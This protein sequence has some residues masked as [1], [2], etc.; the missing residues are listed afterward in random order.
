MN[1]AVSNTEAPEEAPAQMRI[2]A[3]APGENPALT[4]APKFA[5]SRQAARATERLPDLS[6]DS[7]VAADNRILLPTSTHTRLTLDLASSVQASAEERN[8]ADPAFR[9]KVIKAHQL[10]NYR[11]DAHNHVVSKTAVSLPDVSAK[12]HFVV[13]PNGTGQHAIV[14][15]CQR[16]FNYGHGIYE[17]PLPG[18]AQGIRFARMDTIVVQFPP[19]GRLSAFARALVKQINPFFDTRLGRSALSDDEVTMTV[20]SLLLSMNVGLVIVGPVSGRGSLADKAGEIWSMLAQVAVATGIPIVIVCTPG[21]AIN[22]VE[23][24]DGVSALTSRGVYS[25]EPFTLG[26]Q[27]WTNV[28]EL[29]WLKYFF[30]AGCQ[31]PAWFPESLA[32]LTLGNIEYAVTLGSYV[33]S[34]WAAGGKVQLSKEILR[35]HAAHALAMQMP[36]LDAYRDAMQGGTFTL[37]RLKKL[38]DGLPLPIAMQA[39]AKLGDKD[40]YIETRN[41]AFSSAIVEGKVLPTSSN[42]SAESKSAPNSDGGDTA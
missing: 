18:R 41:I 29:I 33:A 10:I 35:A 12:V 24:G 22:L 30:R 2:Y 42:S 8:L 39:L 32:T 23:H 37:Y 21:A 14:H 25:V 3:A 1:T 28:A 9:A 11:R 26:T 36:L 13:A 7:D 27:E 20:Q 16:I 5:N 19:N 15:A 34:V 38:A 40:D 31:R 6:P 4:H 17:V